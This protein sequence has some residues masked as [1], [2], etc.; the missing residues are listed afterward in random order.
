[1]SARNLQAPGG[2]RACAL[3]RAF[4]VVE[5]LVVISI[6][7]VLVAIL[8]PAV[9]MAREAA[10]RTNCMSNL[11][12]ITQA[13][14]EHHGRK[15][16]LPAS[17]SWVPAVA[18]GTSLPGAID[19]TLAFSWVQP[20]LV[21]LDNGP[22]WE[23]I[24]KSPAAGQAAVGAR[25]PVLMCPSD[26]FEGE[27]AS[28]SY[29]INGGRVNAALSA[30]SPNNDWSA[31][32]GSDDRLRINTQQDRQLLRTNR[33][34]LSDIKDGASTTI[35]FAENTYLRT[36][37][38]ENA[39]GSIPEIFSAIIWIPDPTLTFAPVDPS[40][41]T[42]SVAGGV[43]YAR[44]ASRH[45]GGFNMSFWDG[46]ARFVSDSIDYHVYARLMSSNGRRTQAPSD[47][48]WNG[49]TVLDPGPPITQETPLN[50]TEIQ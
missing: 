26:V 15:Q 13:G 44:P 36:W 3:R 33:L 45:T 5:M 8:L 19:E 25:M 39:T 23:S 31:N 46:S 40:D 47:A 18:P 28:L 11:R 50:G 27:T 35:A 34:T 24:L 17:R 48:N 29:A 16:Y 20:M 22:L 12:S 10:R 2:R 43:G 1:M 38:R 41:D 4:T 42:I 9:Q 21:D 7:G 6:I 14:I 30:Q 37:C 49:A 32:G